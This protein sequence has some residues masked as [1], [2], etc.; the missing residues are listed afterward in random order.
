[1]TPEEQQRYRD[2]PE[3]KR[4][5]DETVTATLFEG[6]ERDAAK[7]LLEKVARGEAPALD[8]VSELNLRAGEVEETGLFLTGGPFGSMFPSLQRG[9]ERSTVGDENHKMAL[10][11]AAQAGDTLTGSRAADVVRDLQKAFGEDAAL[12]ERLTNPATEEDRRLAAEFDVAVRR[13]VSPQDYDAYVKP[14][15]ETGHLPIE[16]QMALSWSA[17]DVDEQ[18]VYKDILNAT[19]EEKE[20]ILHD[21]AYQDTVL[22]FM[23]SAER[24]VALNVLEQ[25]E[26]RPEDMIY[27][28]QLGLGSGEEEI[29]AALA[30]VPLQDRERVTTEY[31]R[32]YESDLST[33]LLSELGGL[34]QTQAVRLAR[35]APTSDQEAFDLARDDSYQSR[36]GI[37]ASLVDL[38]WDGSGYM[39]DDALHKY[40]GALSEASAKFEQLPPEQQQE[41]NQQIQ[42]SLDQFRESKGAAADAVVDASIAVVAVGGAFFTDGVSLGLLAATGVGAGMFK[43]G[44]KAAVQGSDYDFGSQAGL[45]FTT[46]FVD[47]ALSFVGPGEMAAV[48]K[49][50]DSAAL[51]ASEKALARGGKEL[52]EGG[53]ETLDSALKQAVRDAVVSGKYTIPD[54][55]LDEIVAQVAKK[56]ATDDDLA[57]LKKF[58]KEGLSESLETESRSALKRIGTEYALE[59][60]SGAIGGGASGMVYG[61]AEWDPELSFADNMSRVATAAGTSAG[62]GAA[63]AA[64]F[65]TLFKAG[66]TGFQAISEH[67]NLKPGERISPEQLDELAKMSGA[68]GATARYNEDGDIE[69]IQKAPASQANLGDVP[70]AVDSPARTGKDSIPTNADDNKPWTP[71]RDLTRIPNEG[72]EDFLARAR[73]SELYK[74]DVVTEFVEGA[75]GV[76]GRWGDLTPLSER[77]AASHSALERARI[78]YENEIIDKLPEDMQSFGWHTDRVRKVLA[79]NP[80]ALEVLDAFVR[81]R[82]ENG[83]AVKQL[84]KALQT[85]QTD[86]QAAVNKFANAQGLPEV[87]VLLQ[88]DKFMPGAAAKYVDGTII[89]RKSSLLNP[90]EAPDL[91]G[92]MYHELAHNEQDYLII[93]S[94]A[95]EIRVGAE[96]TTRQILEI[97]ELYAE[98]TG[99]TLRDEYLLK[100]ISQRD[101]YYLSP[102]NTA[103]AKEL[104]EAFKNNAP[105][106]QAWIDAGNTFRTV[107]G[108]LKRL[109]EGNDGSFKL[110]RDIAGNAKHAQRLFGDEIPPDVRVLIDLYQRKVKGEDIAWPDEKA[111]EV[112][113]DHITRRMEGINVER[114][115]AYDRY[116]AGSHEQEAFVIGERARLMAE[117]SDVPEP[118]GTTGGPE[119]V[120]VGL[121]R[122][123]ADTLVPV[124]TSEVLDGIDTSDRRTVDMRVDAMDLG[125]KNPDGTIKEDLGSS[126][127]VTI[128]GEEYE[129]VREGGDQWYYGKEPPKVSKSPV[130]V[131]V[132]GV[133]AEDLGRLQEVLIPALNDSESGLADLVTGWKTMDPRYAVGDAGARGIG[134]GTSD[135]SA[136]AFTIFAGSAEHALRIQSKIDQIL[137]AHPE[138]RL[139]EIIDTGNVDRVAELSGR[140]GVCREL[141]IA[142]PDSTPAK[143]LI[144][145]DKVLADRIHADLGSTSGNLSYAQLRALEISTQMEPNT[146]SYDSLG[147]L[148]LKCG[149]KSSYQGDA[150][151]VPELGAGK[152]MDV[153]GKL[154]T[155]RPALYALAQRYGIDQADIAAGRTGTDPSDEVTEVFERPT[156]VLEDAPTE[157]IPLPANKKR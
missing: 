37:G 136:K 87:K 134:P 84:N 19:P 98:R 57:Q 149:P 112:L 102:E 154:K 89:L 62:F 39:A 58:I 26:M 52:I 6:A 69:L 110:I 127:L 38:T 124:E 99:G 135:Q 155:D 94:L 54:G 81:R 8:I 9:L 7:H 70:S 144:L 103:R 133:D 108:D 71:E 147:N 97:K 60:S 145:I 83:D 125:P 120:T 41:L 118:R 28:Q 116:M 88:E 152:G 24:K 59:M 96:L 139:D 117:H 22:G 30:E 82:D 106:G 15:L 73:A 122:R 33:D 45:D 153:D 14:L 86:L 151:Y 65:A 91:I 128:G 109:E 114:R 137:S 46:G 138:L 51:A 5:L 32:K 40:A 29:K 101:G 27:A 95:D 92:N 18:G 85:R 111:K 107:R 10:E 50:G 53:T 21:P 131:H 25:G 55:S 146:L 42:S 80:E 130:K 77:V 157:E 104:A 11:K 75:E 142:S 123:T 4:E 68:E 20:R 90:E 115:E 56:G 119:D 74:A 12:R 35:K 44:T 47:G 129:L 79:D 93:R 34:D 148:V 121:P 76:A 31:Q 16:K 36:D 64:G 105:V 156:D 78:Q 48:F 61:V 113:T 49:V 132:F 72:K 126:A 100:A 2:D 66:S 141:Y 143:P 43:V 13:S 3:F 23:S 67:Y 1:M 140:V 63:G 17:S 150:I